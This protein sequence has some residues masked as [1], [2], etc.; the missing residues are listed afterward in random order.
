[1]ALGQGGNIGL[2]QDDAGQALNENLGLSLAEGYDADGRKFDVFSEGLK[3]SEEVRDR[4][5]Q[6][7]GQISD[8]SDVDARIN[9][10]FEKEVT[11]RGIDKI[12]DEEVHKQRTLGLAYELYGPFLAGIEGVKGLIDSNDKLKPHLAKLDDVLANK[13]EG[14]SDDQLRRRQSLRLALANLYNFHLAKETDLAKLIAEIVG[15]VNFSELNDAKREL[16]NDTTAVNVVL[17][18]QGNNGDGIK[19]LLGG[20]AMKQFEGYASGYK[21]FCELSEDGVFRKVGENE[22]LVSLLEALD[23]ASESYKGVKD[24]AEDLG[25]IQRQRTALKSLRPKETLKGIKNLQVLFAFFKKQEVFKGVMSNF[26]G[27][28]NFLNALNSVG[29][30]FSLKNLEDIRIAASSLFN[31]DLP[32]GLKGVDLQW[33]NVSKNLQKGMNDAQRGIASRK[34]TI[35]NLQAQAEHSPSLSDEEFALQIYKYIVSKNPETVGLS[36]ERVESLAKDLHFADMIALDNDEYLRNKFNNIG[37]GMNVAAV[38]QILGFSYQVQGD[39]KENFPLKNLGADDIATVDGLKSAILTE[40]IKWEE[41][42]FLFMMFDQAPIGS[43][44]PSKGSPHHVFMEKEARRLLAE[45][46]G[47]DPQHPNSLKAFDTQMKT[48]QPHLSVYMKKVWKVGM[49]GIVKR[50]MFSPDGYLAKLEKKARG[51]L[52]RL[53]FPSVDGDSKIVDKLRNLGVS[54]PYIT[55]KSK[56]SARLASKIDDWIK[57]RL[58]RGEISEEDFE[59]EVKVLEDLGYFNM[60]RDLGWGKIG[61]VPKDQALLRLE[62][63]FRDSGFWSRKTRQ[64]VLDNVRGRGK[65][66][67][68]HGVRL[69]LKGAWNLGKFGLSASWATTKAPFKLIGFGLRSLSF[70]WPFV[71]GLCALSLTKGLKDGFGAM[72]ES[73]SKSHMWKDTKAS[74]KSI[75]SGVSGAVMDVI[76]SSKHIAWDEIDE[77]DRYKSRAN[78]MKAKRLKRKIDRLKIV[79]NAPDVVTIKSLFID[80]KKYKLRQVNQNTDANRQSA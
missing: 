80:P 61:I 76:R 21:S 17:E 52:K 62:A 54:H 34:R 48:L 58:D 23:D 50:T 41:A 27:L 51:N 28:D 70:A 36:D 60:E 71:K 19:S 39:E 75:G 31:A 12:E 10:K 64:R 5:R 68:W 20:N 69:P 15:E 77:K 3:I 67:L 40:K 43:P 9:E 33:E 24:A 42:C 53:K 2:E 7:Y 30:D 25:K 74:A 47:L 79:L 49:A 73:Y 78:K 8:G 56:D 72:K 14:A 26:V 16:K 13:I 35:A 6:V 65:R 4:I 38:E 18:S 66:L 29:D 44:I 57:E 55:K 11:A 45:E 22:S 1:M 59:S 63:M 32:A 37:V 46:L